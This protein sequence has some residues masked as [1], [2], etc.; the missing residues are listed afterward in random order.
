M[1]LKNQK[2]FQSPIRI[3]TLTWVVLM[4]GS[5]LIFSA[6]AT[7]VI[8]NFNDILPATDNLT[9]APGNMTDNGGIGF[10]GNYTETA[11]SIPALRT[12][13]LTSSLAHYV[14]GQTGTS[15]CV[16]NRAG[17]YVLGSLRGEARKTQPLSG[18]V[19]FSFLARLN[20]KGEMAVGFNGSGNTF[21]TITNS[22]VKIC[23]GSTNSAG[24]FGIAATGLRLHEISVGVNGVL[25]AG[26]FLPTDSTTILVLGR[27]QINAS[28]TNDIIDVWNDPDVADAASL[29]APALSYTGDVISSTINNLNFT[30]ARQPSALDNAVVDN[31]KV[32][33]DANAFDIVYLNADLPSYVSISA[34]ATNIFEGSA[35]TP[36]LVSRTGNLNNAITVYYNVTGTAV[37]GVDYTTLS[38]QV[39]LPAGEAQATVALNP[40][41]DLEAEGVESVTLTVS[42][43][44]GYVVT[45]ASSASI[46]IADN[47]VSIAATS[48]FAAE[49]STPGAFTVSR[50][51]TANIPLTIYYEISGTASNGVDYTMLPGQ[52]TIPAGQYDAVIAVNPIDDLNAEG[53]ETVI[54][55]LTTNNF[56]V[57]GAPRT[58]T[59][60]ID[61]DLEPSQ[62]WV[63]ATDAAA[64]ERL[65]DLTGKFTVYR[66]DSSADGTVNFTLGGTAVLGVDYLPSATNSIA[67]LAGETS[68]TIAI[69]PIGNTNVDGARTIILTIANGSGYGLY[70][71]TNALVTLYDDDLP[72]EQVLFSDR[73]ETTDSA[74]NYL[75]LATDLTGGS[76]Y[77]AQFAYDYSVDGVPIAPNG[78]TTSSLGLKITA[79]K[80][81]TASAAVVNLIPTNV[82]ASG[83]FALRF[84]LY[85][86]WDSLSSQGEYALAGINHT[87]TLTNWI[88]HGSP[89]FNSGDGQFVT[90][91]GND[92]LVEGGAA[93]LFTPTNSAGA[94]GIVD[95][96][97]LRGSER[98]K[99]LADMLD[100]PPY[101]Y[102]GNTNSGVFGCDVGSSTKQ[103]VDCELSQ[104]GNRVSFKANGATVLTYTNTSG[105]TNG[106][107]MIGYN[108]SYS[109]VSA[110]P[111]SYFAI[112]DN[113][114]VV[115]LPSSVQ[116]VIS[117]ITVSGSTVTVQFS[118]GVSDVAGSFKLQSSETVNGSYTDDNSAIVTGSGGNLQATTSTNGST[119]FYRIRRN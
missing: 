72:A 47:S 22:P 53:A 50:V 67:F 84:E 2:P 17:A 100:N 97:G 74:T 96:T 39:L 58:A 19:W 49:P 6:K 40:I 95:G 24:A 102:I 62:A 42:N 91:V 66:N 60:T 79:N 71:H 37:N 108:D 103:W 107:V 106:Y 109:G 14:A 35:P 55:N 94:V 36:F 68:K 76:D 56:Y 101:G 111:S 31:V 54:L 105:F 7:S 15:M 65:S 5:F 70:A 16:S 44:T 83:N 41:D 10:I 64:Y 25:T 48:P 89:S 43:S 85:M 13:D 90:I 113:V 26:N 63:M 110:I 75:V 104:I 73:F 52:V 46:S 115:S 118:A 51:G 77:S 21:G 87:G 116:P 32:S 93:T 112:F 78:P 3:A 98:S 57:L 119:R 28:G 88:S 4:V 9:F 12:F 81:G 1:S 20:G 38:G 11:T 59:N 82:V 45:G 61:D 29:P 117:G 69:T 92:S 86:Q 23:L 114:R 8:A 33:D 18:T 34:S 80:T 30:F 99:I 27:I